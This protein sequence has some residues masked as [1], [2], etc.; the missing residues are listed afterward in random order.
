[1]RGGGERSW[2]ILEVPLKRKQIVSSTVPYEK[3]FGF[4]A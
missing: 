3:T 1:M 2:E 4:T